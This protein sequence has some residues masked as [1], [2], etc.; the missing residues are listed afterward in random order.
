LNAPNPCLM[1]RS[2][3]MRW[4]WHWSRQALRPA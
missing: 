3:K 4:S 2:P 1:R